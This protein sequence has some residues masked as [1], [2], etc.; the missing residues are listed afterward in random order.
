MTGTASPTYFGMSQLIPT[1]AAGFIANN[2]AAYDLPATA[3]ATSLLTGNVATITGM[4]KTSATGTVTIKFA[5][6]LASA[7]VVKAGS[8][9]E[10]W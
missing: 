3:S 10:V 9:L 4:I 7:I 8:S 6:E 5:S 1:T 2:V